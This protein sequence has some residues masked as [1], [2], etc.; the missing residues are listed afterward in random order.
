MVLDFKVNKG[1]AQRSPFFMSLPFLLLPYCL[2]K[3]DTKNGTLRS[4]SSPWKMAAGIISLPEQRVNPMPVSP[5]EGHS[6]LF[7]LSVGPGRKH[8]WKKR[9]RGQMELLNQC[10]CTKRYPCGNLW[11]PARFS[12]GDVQWVYFIV[13]FV[14]ALQR[15]IFSAY[16]PNKYAAKR[17]FPAPASPMARTF[18]R[19]SAM[20]N[21]AASSH[22]QKPVRKPAQGVSLSSWG[23]SARAVAR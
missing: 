6:K 23:K 1:W 8:L 12:M 16:S 18:L 9:G 13:L 20:F 21:K 7:R 2:Q 22:R 15:Y 3:N 4:M 11:F 10:T 5:A 17:Y 14:L 19:I